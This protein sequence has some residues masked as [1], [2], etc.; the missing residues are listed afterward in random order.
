MF[1]FPHL[2]LGCL[3][4]L[5][6]RGYTFEHGVEEGMGFLSSLGLKPLATA[7]AVWSESEGGG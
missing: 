1:P 7:P 2:L 6:G 5:V 4:I 3:G